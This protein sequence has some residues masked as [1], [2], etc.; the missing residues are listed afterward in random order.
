MASLRKKTLAIIGA[1]FVGLI[2]V[3]FISSQMIIMNSFSHLEQEELKKDMQSARNS[4]CSEI[5]NLEKKT[6]DWSV[7]DE[8]YYFVQE[9]DQGYID[10]YLMDETFINQKF[11]FVLFYNL[12]RELVYAKSVVVQPGTQVRSAQNLIDHLEENRSLLEH[13]DPEGRKTGVLY[14]DEEFMIITSQPIV[15]GYGNDSIGGTVLMGRFLDEEEIG[16]LS[17]ENNLELNIRHAVDT[18]GMQQDPDLLLD[19]GEYAYIRPVNASRIYGSVLMNDIYGEPAMILDVGIPRSIYMHGKATIAYFLMT[20]LLSGA[21]FGIVV[22]SLLEN[23][24]LA[25]LN[26]LNEDIRHIG[27]SRDFSRRI[28]EEG[29]DEISK[30]IISINRM[31]ES[32]EHSEELV[33]KRDTTIKAI[34]QAMPDMVFQIKKDGTILNYKLSTEEC[35]YESPN[36]PPEIK[37]EDLLPHDVAAKELVII[38]KVLRTGKMQT[39]QYQL[40]VKG[41]MRDFEVRIVVS[42]EDEVMSVVKDITEIKQSED[43]RKKDILLKEIHHRVKNNL[44]VMSSLLRL[45]SKRFRD[46]E[47]IEAFRESQHRAKSMALAHE[48]LYHS[49][50]LENIDL[51][52]YIPKLIKYLVNSYGFSP[53]DIKTHINIKNII[54]GIDTSIPIGLI[55]TELVSN[56]LKYAFKEGTGEINVELYPENGKFI[57]KVSDNGIGFPE[58]MDFRETDS[59]GLQLVN[60]LVEQIEGTIELDRKNGSAFK[61]TFEELSY[62][63]RDY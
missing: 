4:M 9:Y 7:W 12:S 32:L 44:Q 50:D 59:L 17:D 33:S 38:E 21:V 42:G 53:D 28:F 61:I 48:N 40:P 51:Q 16:I 55:I 29:D 30:L 34:I 45:Q 6:V 5:E 20:L 24:Y 60:S 15:T 26:R 27:E 25:R 3:L 63:R 8:T 62:K 31:L 52:T 10:N 19:S 57:L 1:T 36:M 11:D 14:V 43:A 13:L 41:E 46:R 37:I 39:M 58:Y 49:N 35:L 23:S 54:F 47:V 22:L 2:F 18:E 56:S